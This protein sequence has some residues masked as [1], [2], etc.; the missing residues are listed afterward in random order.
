MQK[1]VVAEV[2]AESFAPF[3]HQAAV[4]GPYEEEQ[5]RDIEFRESQY[6]VFWMQS[7]QPARVLRT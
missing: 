2:I 1:R 6:F 7:I 5:K 4:V 3:D